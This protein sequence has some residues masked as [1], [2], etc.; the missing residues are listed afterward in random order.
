MNRPIGFASGIVPGLPAADTVSAAIAGGFDMVGLWVEPPHWTAATTREV[1]SRVADGGI[2]VLDVEVVWI[3]PGPDDPD[4]FRII[5]IG[6]EVGARNVLVVSSDPDTGAAAAK[7]ARL[8]D[9]GAERGLRVCLEF[10]LFTEVHRLADARA[11]VEATDSPARGIL[12][13]PLHLHR[14]G[15]TPAEVAALPHELLP[16]A[17][18]CDAPAA[19]PD[20]GDLASIREDALDRRQQAGEGGLPLA[21]LLVALPPDIPLSIELRSRALREAWP[22]PADRARVTARATRAFLAARDQ[23]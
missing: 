4:H 2:G 17:Q 6:A 3:R 20:L 8:C 23:R 5:D 7:Y 1:R 21:A 18:F 22:D 16:Y 12:I 19:L 10:G 11:I 13:D 14:S 9:H 15:G